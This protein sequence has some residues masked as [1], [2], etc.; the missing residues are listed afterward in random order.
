MDFSRPLKLAAAILI[1]AAF[2]FLLYQANKKRPWDA[3]Q[4]RII[5]DT[6]E[7]RQRINVP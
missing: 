4:E 2:F 3:Y 6:P 5:V 1:V 7:E